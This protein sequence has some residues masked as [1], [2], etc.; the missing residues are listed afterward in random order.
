MKKYFY[1]TKEVAEIL[2]C[3]ANKVRMLI[4]GGKLKAT[5]VGKDLRVPVGALNEFVEVKSFPHEGSGHVR[6]EFTD[7]PQVLKTDLGSIRYRRFDGVTYFCVTDVGGCLA[8]SN[9]KQALNYPAGMLFFEKCGNGVRRWISYLRLN[10]FESSRPVRLR[11]KDSGLFGVLF[12]LSSAVP[13]VPADTDSSPASENAPVN[14]V[15][16]VPAVPGDSERLEAAFSNVAE[17]INVLA[18]S[19]SGLREVVFDC[20]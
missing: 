5:R 6:V 20:E 2:D 8:Y 17:A 1:T 13:S 15:P 12:E 4:H 10:D 7:S 11:L 19:L 18:D 14:A 3:S 16:S 9:I